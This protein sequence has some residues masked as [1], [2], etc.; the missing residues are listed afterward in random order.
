[1]APGGTANAAA[2]V[3]S[4]GGVALLGGVVGRDAIGTSLSG[5]EPRCWS[6]LS[7]TSTLVGDQYLGLCERSSPTYCV[8]V[9]IELF[10]IPQEVKKS[11]VIAF[12]HIANHLG[13]PTPR[14]HA[15]RGI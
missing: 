1:V 13:N 2:N 15:T 8:F 5:L 4:L 7:K 9:A 11:S 12:E 6:G 3:V 14:G 10:F